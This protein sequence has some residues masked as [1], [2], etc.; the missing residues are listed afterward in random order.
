MSGPASLD[1]CYA[2]LR[3]AKEHLELFEEEA[4]R[5]L[6]HVP[7]TTVFEVTYDPDVP[8]FLLGVAEE[9]AMSMRLST[10]A[11]DLVHN[12]RS[13]LDHLAY[14]LLVLA[15]DEWDDSRWPIVTDL[16]EI[17]SNRRFRGLRDRLLS[18]GRDDFWTKV[19][20][21]Q[22]HDYEQTPPRDGVHP[23]TQRYRDLPLFMLRELSNADRHRLLLEPYFNVAQYLRI[24]ARCIR[25]CEN[26]RLI[27]AWPLFYTLKKDAPP[28]AQFTADITGP[29]AHMEVDVDFEAQPVGFVDII[30]TSASAYLELTADAV[31]TVLQDFAPLF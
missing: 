31:F 28:I 3:R 27:E 4:G 29:D 20:S 24:E 7:D 19:L 8:R 14:Q 23:L 22:M 21:H 10:I 1:G 15:G 13:C 5:V 17:D 26:P 9:P 30:G 2:K 12:L 11:G 18:A 6:E 25:D 16:G